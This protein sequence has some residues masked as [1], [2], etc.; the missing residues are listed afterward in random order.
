M[1]QP[2]AQQQSIDKKPSR[3]ASRRQG[4][5]ADDYVDGRIAAEHVIVNMSAGHI[6]VAM[7]DG[8]VLH[9]AP[10]EHRK[11]THAEV[12][13][14]DLD[15]VRRSPYVKIERV[16][17]RLLRPGPA[18]ILRGVVAGAVL[19][20]VVA[21]PVLSAL[22]LHHL[23]D[24]VWLTVMA[25]V[26]AAA[27]ILASSYVLA[28]SGRGHLFA[29]PDIVRE[30]RIRLAHH[31][32]YVA[33]IVA[34]VVIPGVVTWYLGG[35]R[36]AMRGV[37]TAR[38]VAGALEGLFAGPDN[39]A[40]ALAWLLQLVLISS[41]SMLPALL[42]FVFDRTRL[43]TLKHQLLQH[44][45][46]LERGLQTLSEVDA[47]YGPQISE[48]FG[49]GPKNSGRF[50]MGTRLPVVF[51]TVLIAAGWTVLMVHTDQGL[52]TDVSQPG[53]RLISF[54]SSP[55][56]LVGYAFLGAYVFALRLT[57]RGYMRHDLRTKSYSAISV[58]LLSVVI[59]AW[60]LKGFV[61]SDPTPSAVWLAAAFF[62]GFFPDE[63]LRGL[64]E[65]VTGHPLF[66]NF[67]AP[68][69]PDVPTNDLDTLAGLD[70]YDR[71][72]LAQE[73]IN[74]VQGLAKADLVTLLMNVRVPADRLFDWVDQAVLQLYVGACGDPGQDSDEEHPRTMR[75]RLGDAGI[76]AATQVVRAQEVPSSMH[77]HDPDW[78]NLRG[79]LT[80]D[81]TVRALCDYSTPAERDRCPEWVDARPDASHDETDEG[82]RGDAG[83][84]ALRLWV[85]TIAAERTLWSLR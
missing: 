68:K 43:G 59:L 20:P 11:M 33:V 34:A 42:F 78:K 6:R 30:A 83:G 70:V 18:R 44:I 85:P 32:S 64:K 53:F 15:K 46:R 79:A 47:K 51:A 36:S 10:L 1:L 80:A 26:A 23:M 14:I 21:I 24:A 82:R 13:H 55:P 35:F 72:R 8:H 31:A 50:A 73:G 69:W 60:L 58:R 45:F 17:D 27:L 67:S 56:E 16:G 75:R 49:S 22:G 65:Y 2:T 38:G 9:L 12:S 76:R 28:S 41:A 54:W 37:T 84:G 61:P 4:A 29:Y 48:T 66:R 62:V 3:A 39:T 77:G 57:L 7:G 71:A 25:L 5:K 81:L 40:L 19:L 74:N 63:W 52:A